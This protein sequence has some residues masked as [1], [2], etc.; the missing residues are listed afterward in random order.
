MAANTT[1]KL[2]DHQ[3]KTPV[4]GGFGAAMREAGSL[5]PGMMLFTDDLR[6]AIKCEP[7]IEAYPDRFVENGIAE[8]NMLG[9]AAGAASCGKM[10]FVISYATFATWRVAEQLRNDVSYPNFNVK[11]VSMTTG[12]TFGQGGMSHQ[13]FADLTL[14]R[15]LPNFT[16]MVPADTEAHNAA[17]LTAANHVGPMFLRCGRDDAALLK[18]PFAHE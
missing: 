15:C 9:M 4:R 11:I 1:V 2:G 7:F 17:V 6:D 12:V 14:T 13:T 5:H 8:Q 10:P 16:V 3:K 18:L